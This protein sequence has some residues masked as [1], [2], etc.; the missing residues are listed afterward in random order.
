M[1]LE[2]L[3]GDLTVTLRVRDNF[4]GGAGLTSKAGA[5]VGG[6]AGLADT[7]TLWMGALG[8]FV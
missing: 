1:T 8:L 6:A 2:T 7:N 4:E 3:S 5:A